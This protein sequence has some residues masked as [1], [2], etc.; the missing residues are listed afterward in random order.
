MKRKIRRNRRNLTRTIIWPKMKQ[1][2]SFSSL[3]ISSRIFKFM[4]LDYSTVDAGIVEPPY[5]GHHRDY[6][7][8]S[9]IRRCPL[10]RVSAI[11]GSTVVAKRVDS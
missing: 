2:A 4:S 5:Y 7:L 10:Y 3:V 1:N 8:V 9:V 6:A 11:G